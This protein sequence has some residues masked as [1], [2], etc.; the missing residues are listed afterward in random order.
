MTARRKIQLEEVDLNLLVALQALLETSSVTEAANRV[1]VTQSA[2][3]RSLRRIRSLLGDDV[4]VRSKQGMVPTPHAEAMR[5]ELTAALR[6]LQATIRSTACFVP[7]EAARTFRICTTDRAQLRFATHLSAHVQREAPHIDLLFRGFSGESS[8][9]ELN[10]GDLDIIVARELNDPNDQLVCKLLAREPMVCAVR[11]DHP[12]IGEE[13]SVEEYAALPHIGYTAGGEGTSL[14]DELLAARGLQRQVTLRL[15]SFLS[16]PLILARSK[17]ILTAP[18]GLLE[19][20]RDC[21]LLRL[22]K[23]P[24]DLP[25]VL[26]FAYWHR[27]NQDDPAMLWLRESIEAAY[28]PLA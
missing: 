23:P 25:P 21:L 11:A 20:Y 16:T 1:G 24:L 12:H 15:Q 10:A 9:A 13:L 17:C 3:S 2:M 6:H 5:D 22:L 27:R 28:S 18:V 8:V 14:I 19:A 26:T 4:L 7:T